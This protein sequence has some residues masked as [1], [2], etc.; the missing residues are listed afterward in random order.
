MFSFSGKNVLVWTCIRT[1][2]VF[3]FLFS[4]YRFSLE[5]S[6]SLPV[7]EREPRSP[8]MWECFHFLGKIVLVWTFI[9]TDIV[10]IFLFNHYRFSFELSL[11]L[12]VDEREPSSAVMWA[13]FHFL[14]KIVLVWTCIRTDFVFLFLFSHYRF[15]FKLSLSLPVDE[16]ERRS[17]VMWECFHFLREIVLVWTCIRTDF[18]FLFLFNHYRFSLELSLS[19]PLDDRERSS[20]VMWEC[21][22]FLG[23]IVL[24]WTFIRT[25]FV[26]LFLFNHYHFSFELS[27][28]LPVDE[29]EPRSPV[30]WECFHFLGKIV[31]VWT[32]IRTD[33]VFLFVFNHYRF[34]FELSLSLPVDDREP[35]SAVMWECFHFLGK[36]YW[37]ER[38]YALT[39]FSFFFLVIT[40]FHL[41]CPSPSQ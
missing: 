30:M 37:F 41:N 17:P 33:F 18:V 10:F 27:L 34:S 22:H 35:C 16:K 1:D 3:L 13:C 5:L 32:F 11:S 21:F 38:A 25:D 4:H 28:S 31:L 8:V 6:L 36:M 12:P 26:F 39:L 20:A 23:K 19:L 2:L 15:S 14:G 40:V 9:G 24:V 7:D 29:R